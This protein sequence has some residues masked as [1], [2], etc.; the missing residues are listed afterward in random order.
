[1]LQIRGDSKDTRG[2]LNL[3][4]ENHRDVQSTL[5]QSPTT[6]GFFRTYNFKHPFK[7]F[8]ENIPDGSA[9]CK[10]KLFCLVLVCA[11]RSLIQKLKTK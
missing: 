9:H 3:D 11:N 6:T 5:Q 1:V 10:A 7:C 2:K 4:P 8:R